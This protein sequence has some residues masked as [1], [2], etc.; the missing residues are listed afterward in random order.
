MKFR[1]ALIVWLAIAPVVRGDDTAVFN[2]MFGSTAAPVQ[3]AAEQPKIETV[4][5]AE[6]KPELDKKVLLENLQKLRE[7]LHAQAQEAA[8][9]GPV[10]LEDIYPVIL[11]DVL[12]HPEADRPFLRYLDLT[13][14][15]PEHRQDLAACASFVLNSLSWSNDIVVPQVVANSDG[16]ILRFNYSWYCRNVADLENWFAAWELMT[17]HDPYYRQPWVPYDYG[18]AVSVATGSQGCILRADWFIF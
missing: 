3:A 17:S 1:V 16:R 8:K 14:V 6:L 15:F 10:P 7:S 12:A 11:Q 2:R 5:V 13:A 9:P 4:P 18:T